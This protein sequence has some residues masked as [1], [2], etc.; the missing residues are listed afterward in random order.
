[1]SEVISYNRAKIVKK[2]SVLSDIDLFI[3]AINIDKSWNLFYQD[4]ILGCLKNEKD[5]TRFRFYGNQ[6]KKVL[7]EWFELQDVKKLKSTLVSLNEILEQ[8]ILAGVTNLAFEFTP[9]LGPSYAYSFCLVKTGENELCI[10]DIIY[11]GER[12]V[13]RV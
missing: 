12:I 13:I 11:N 9:T 1:M 7:K 6:M 8:P 2:E 5:A 3:N 10:R 4:D